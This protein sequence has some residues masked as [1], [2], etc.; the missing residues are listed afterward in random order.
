MGS[1]CS[2]IAYG[3]VWFVVTSL[4]AHCPPPSHAARPSFI[5]RH[6]IILPLPLEHPSEMYGMFTLF[7]FMFFFACVCMCVR[8]RQHISAVNSMPCT[9]SVIVLFGREDYI[10]PHYYR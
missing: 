6:I 2:G 5:Y 7:Y 3:W 1:I 10:A 9:L 4:N 8:F